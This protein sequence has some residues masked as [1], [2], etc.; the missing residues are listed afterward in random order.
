M[1]LHDYQNGAV[2]WLRR[3]RRGVVVSPAGSGKTIIAAAAL[4]VVVGAKRRDRKVRIGWMANTKEQVQQAH[5][6]LR[7]FPI[8]KEHDVKVA[9]AAADTDWSDR[10]V[11]VS[12]ECHHLPSP[13]WR[14]Q[15]E[16]CQ[17][18]CWGFTATPDYEGFDSGNRDQV[19]RDLFDGNIYFV[20]RDSV[21]AQVTHARVVL[22]DPPWNPAVSVTIDA[23]T[24]RVYRARSRYW[25]GSLQE[26]RAMVLW[27]CCIKHG[28]VENRQRNISALDVTKQH[29]LKSDSVLMLVNQV[30]HAKTMANALNEHSGLSWAIA[31]HSGMG[32]KKRR[33]ALYDFKTGKVPCIVATSLADEGLDVPRANVLML[34]SGGK[35]KARTEQRTGRVLRAFAGKEHG[36]IYDFLDSHHPLMAKHAQKRI[37]LY[38]E[39]GYEIEQ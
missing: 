37:A 11:L 9:C 35:N 14:T 32:A 10:D 28:I 30:E 5:Q 18:A 24:E 12:D 36:L 26:L 19:F 34:V 27:Q 33:H 16:R 22:L 8:L 39:L 20:D 17:G 21:K 15:F 4:A 2:E 31:C 7:Q 38:Q 6:A 13:L 29:I 3:Q 23:E 25:R 1:T